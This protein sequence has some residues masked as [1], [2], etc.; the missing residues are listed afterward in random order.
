MLFDIHVFKDI[1][2]DIG[3]YNTNDIN[4]YNR[5]KIQDHD[6][7]FAIHKS[8]TLGSWIMFLCTSIINIDIT[9]QLKY[10]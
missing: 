5:K 7:F 10:K 8:H 1:E 2:N 6:T 4:R 3:T 9:Q